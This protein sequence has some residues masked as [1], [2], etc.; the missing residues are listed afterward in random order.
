MKRY[1]YSEPLTD[2]RG[3]LIEVGSKVAY[4]YS[5]QVAYGKVLE[6]R[7]TTW[8]G[9]GDGIGAKIKI[10]MDCRVND[11]GVIKKPGKISIIGSP[12]NVLVLFEDN[13]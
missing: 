12:K 13:A 7:P 10:E 3:T 8:I 6:A 2:N 5:G 1:P 11:G 4:N 9:K